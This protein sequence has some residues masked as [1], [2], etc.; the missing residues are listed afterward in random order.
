M[1]RKHGLLAGA[2]CLAIISGTAVALGQDAT[3]YSYDELGRLTGSTIT[4]GANNGKRT[5]T[6]FDR[7]G[8][9]MRYDVAAAAPGACPAPGP[10]PTPVPTPTPTPAP[11]PTPTPPPV[12]PP[13][14][15]I[16][17]TA[18]AVEGDYLVYRVRKVGSPAATYT[19]DYA[20]ANGT[21][22]AG[23]DYTA[24]SGTLTFAP[25]DTVKI[26]SVPT[27]DDTAIENPETLVINLS[28]ASGGATISVAQG[29]GTIYDN[30]INNQ[31]PVAV[32]DTGSLT[33]CSADYFD[34]LA[35]DYDPDG[36][37]P[38]SL[39]SVSVDSQYGT[40]TID[41]NKIYFTSLAV[42]GP[43][44][45]TYTMRDSLGGTASATLTLGIGGRCEP[46]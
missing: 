20:T 11:T 44:V 45:V 35:N 9:R 39:I 1:Q 23:S 12:W 38:L 21:A 7:A 10:V 32:N 24:T 46:G 27:T 6:C 8:N 26:I 43:A 22:T 42:P 33:K 15:E 4:G 16:S 3:T 2:A 29:S 19:V 13:E 14:F 36:N 17:A 31:P 25:A 40:A 41:N 30:D 5:G 34:V 28:N 18:A 37:T